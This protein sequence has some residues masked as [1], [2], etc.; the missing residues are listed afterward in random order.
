MLILHFIH[1]KFIFMMENTILFTLSLCSDPIII[2][3]KFFVNPSMANCTLKNGVFT[4]FGE[5]GIIEKISYEHLI[6]ESVDC[7]S[8]C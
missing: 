2:Q 1:N 4:N 5:E 6:Y 8:L 7:S 3:T